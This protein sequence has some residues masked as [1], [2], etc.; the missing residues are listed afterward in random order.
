M[1][2]WAL[3]TSVEYTENN[4][5]NNICEELVDSILI[6]LLFRTIIGQYFWN[7]E[8]GGKSLANAASIT[9]INQHFQVKYGRSILDEP[10]LGNLKSCKNSGENQFLL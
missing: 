5:F 9:V 10:I 7:I 2:T 6:N 8:K 4:D 3:N 1:S